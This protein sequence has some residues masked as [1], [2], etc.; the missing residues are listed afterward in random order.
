[1]LPD[2]H[3][4]QAMSEFTLRIG[5]TALLIGIAVQGC[6][7]IPVGKMLFHVVQLGNIVVMPHRIQTGK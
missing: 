6:N 5:L 3:A 1:M 4:T 2:P 7:C